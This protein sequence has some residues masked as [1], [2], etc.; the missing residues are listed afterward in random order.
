MRHTSYLEC[1]PRFRISWK[2]GELQLLWL[3]KRLVHRHR[4]QTDYRSRL[5]HFPATITWARLGNGCHIPR[6]AT[7]KAV[8]NLP[9]LEMAHPCL[10][11]SSV[12]LPLGYVLSALSRQADTRASR[13]TWMH[14][15]TSK[16]LQMGVRWLSGYGI[17]LSIRRLPAR[18]SAATN[19]VVSLGNT[20][21][22]LPQECPCTYCKSL[23]LRVSAKWQC[24]C[25]V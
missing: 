25:H 22:Y 16:Q 1:L 7:L 21:P 14:A 11:S 17:R 10:G 19:D 18:F 9:S 6:Q 2:H 20:S 24:K 12:C 5:V 8:I 3:L 23:R 4:G 15:H 13:P